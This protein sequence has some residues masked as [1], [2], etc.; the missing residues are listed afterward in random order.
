M[1]T[2]WRQPHDGA[3]I[4]IKPGVQKKPSFFGE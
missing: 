2:Q 3:M 1:T 4:G